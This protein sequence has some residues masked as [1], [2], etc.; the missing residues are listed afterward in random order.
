MHTMI[1]NNF[2]KDSLK[3]IFPIVPH[4]FSN[5]GKKKKKK[6][7]KKQQKTKKKQK[8]KNKTKQNPKYH[9]VSSALVA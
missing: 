2:K 3:Y 4:V 6:K 9:K 8:K 7:K 1:G 5:F